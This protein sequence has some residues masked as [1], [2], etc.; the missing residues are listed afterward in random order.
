MRIKTVLIAALL[1][2]CCA[3]LVAVPAEAYTIKQVFTRISATAGETLTTGAAVALKDSDGK[4]YKAQANSATVRPALGV[5]GHGGAAGDKIEIITSGIVTGW[6]SLAEGSPGYLSDTAGAITQSSPTY[7]QQMGIAITSTDYYISPINFFDTSSLT[8]LGVLS[9]ATPLI[10]EGATADAYETT[11]AVTDPT[12]DN[13]ITLPDLSGTVAMVSGAGAKKTLTIVSTNTVLTAADC[14][15]VLG[16]G[17]DART[18]TLP[19]TTAGCTYTIINTGGNGNNIVEL[20]PDAADQV[21]GTVTLASSVVV[22][23]GA[24]GEHILNT[25]VTAKR[26]DSMSLIGDGVDG[27]YI[28]AST[29]IW[30]E[31]T[32]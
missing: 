12:A 6:T 24:T 19:P 9:G 8:A 20:V 4:A 3:A 1:L 22:I 30:A 27:W 10:F 14:G 29:G 32:P 26:G 18:I 23:A 13:T 28:T 16:I 15:K 21:F 5:V 11:M 31:A 2:A 17:T 25:K 7:S